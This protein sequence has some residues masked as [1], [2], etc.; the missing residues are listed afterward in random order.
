MADNLKALLGFSKF[1]PAKMRDFARGTYMGMKDNPL[2]DM[3][4]VPMEDL[5]AKIEK[6]Y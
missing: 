4:P 2:H 3:P 5:A 6:I 1:S